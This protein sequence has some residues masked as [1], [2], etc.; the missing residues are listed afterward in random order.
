MSKNLCDQK[1][2]VLLRLPPYSIRQIN[3]YFFFCSDILG[4]L[5]VVSKLFFQSWRQRGDGFGR[6]NIRPTSKWPKNINWSKWTNG[7]SEVYI[8]GKCGLSS[9]SFASLLSC[10]SKTVISINMSSTAPLGEYQM[11]MRDVF[12]NMTS[13]AKIAKTNEEE[14]DNEHN[15]VDNA[16][17]VIALF[18]RLNT[19]TCSNMFVNDLFWFLRAAKVATLRTLKCVRNNDLGRS[20]LMSIDH[21]MVQQLSELVIEQCPVDAESILRTLEMVKEGGIEYTQQLVKNNGNLKT[22]TSSRTAT[23][24]P[25]HSLSLSTG[26]LGKGGSHLNGATILRWLSNHSDLIQLHTLSLQNSDIEFEALGEYARCSGGS[27]K[28]LFIGGRLTNDD[29]CKTLCLNASKIPHLEKI[30]F[31]QSPQLTDRGVMMLSSFGSQLISLNVSWCHLLTD[32]CIES[33]TIHLPHL[34]EL[35]VSHCKKISDRG[36]KKVLIVE[37]KKNKKYVE[38][39]EYGVDDSHLMLIDATHCPS[40]FTNDRR[41]V[42]SVEYAR[43]KMGMEI[44]LEGSGRV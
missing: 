28:N 3:S 38:S 13:L 29:V 44:L 5:S 32:Q 27:I 40:I 12:S 4:S 18:P 25:L 24:L 23:L 37:K 16:G 1:M 41:F 42:K 14:A 2:H 33:V 7:V 22:T 11:N 19:L 8:D 6:L 10:I 43:N 20:E 30:S 31:N 35:I 21:E 26:G 17:D 15:T 36:I 39:K 34:R 9:S